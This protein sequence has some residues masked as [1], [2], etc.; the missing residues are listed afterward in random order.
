MNI[1]DLLILVGGLAL[2]LYGMNLMGDGLKK[3][4]G[5]RL[6][7]ILEKLTS[8]PLK[9][10]LLGAGVTAVIQSSSATT[11]MVVGFVNSGMMQLEQTVG[12][13]MGANIGTTVTSWLLSLTGIHG[14]NIWVKLLE[15]ASFSPILA[16]IGVVFTMFSKDEKKQDIGTIFIGF[17]VIMFGMER[18][19]DAVAPLADVPEFKNL[20]IRFSNPLYGMLA[21]AVLT[22]IIQSSSASVGILQALCATGAVPY[23]V[24][25]P[26]IMGQ[27]IGTC[28]TALLASVGASKNSKRT[29]FIHLYF[30]LIGTCV[31]MAVF[32][33]LH[34]FL[35]FSFLPLAA[36]EVGIA[37]IH[38]AFNISATLFLLPFSRVLVSLARKTLPDKNIED[39]NRAMLDLL[40]P[41]F[42]EKPGYAVIQAKKVSEY[43]VEETKAIFLISRSLLFQYQKEEFLTAE[44]KETI[45]KEYHQNLSKYLM[46]ISGR[47]LLESD[48][49]MIDILL[50]CM[51]DFE[52]ISKHALEIAQ[53]TKE[54]K[55]QKE[56]FSKQAQNELEGIMEEIDSML[57]LTSHIFIT[58]N[59]R[60]GRTVISQK[61][62]V[63]EL[64][65]KCKKNHIKRLRK[66]KC[67]A[68]MGVQYMDILFHCGGIAEHC[69]NVIKCMEMPD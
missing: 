25:I 34:Q 69:A 18:M 55:R 16:I 23:S 9:G 57:K 63:Q 31:F 59:N 68:G 35:Q 39:E 20:M 27:N 11:V 8:S 60:M 45:L 44:G 67:T 10:V 7:G 36:S 61:N 28:I 65:A 24:A 56:T 17:A 46:Q 37:V 4:S 1:F 48:S 50:Q 52:R 26:I 15:P 58:G 12:V 14:E 30:N 47:H 38:S 53:K 54:I 32:Y 22:A 13:I 66:G 51:G 3:V 64:M 33:S 41:R 62:E 42:L 29:A 40:E 43:I 21:G 5:G 2:F 49:Y 19:S 6:E